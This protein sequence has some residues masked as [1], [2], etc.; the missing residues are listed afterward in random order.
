MVGESQ[1]V[2]GGPGGGEAGAGGAQVVQV[3]GERKVHCSQ[4]R[5]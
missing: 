4:L 5:F 2:Q 3:V 1:V